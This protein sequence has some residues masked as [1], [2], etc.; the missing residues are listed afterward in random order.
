MQSILENLSPAQREAV[1]H[2]DGP[3]LILAG[4]GSGKTR[5]V[6]H[7]VAWLLEQGV[8]ASSIVALTFT[9]KAADEMRTRLERLAPGSSVWIGT[10]HRFG[11][12]FLRQYA[13]RVGLK[14]NFSILDARDS[15]TLVGDVIRELGIED[16]M[17]SPEAVARA[18]SAAKAEARG[19]AAASASADFWKASPPSAALMTRALRALGGTVVPFIPDRRSDGYDL[20]DAGVNAAIA[21]GASLVL[22]CD[23]GTSAMAAARRLQAAGIDL[24]ISDHHLP[25]GPLPPAVAVLNPQRTDKPYAEVGRDLDADRGKIAPHRGKIKPYAEVGR[26]LAAVGVA[27]LLVVAASSFCSPPK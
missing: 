24:I 21:A 9:N 6:T 8:A 13:P 20:T 5:V 14:E 4:P 26:D 7:R 10:F 3:M 17:S 19:A 25:G 27:F 16:L 18:I 1:T 11:A 22:T 23:C 15:L 12:Q 2:R